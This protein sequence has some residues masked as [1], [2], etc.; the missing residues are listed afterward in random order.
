MINRD[1]ILYIHMDNT[2]ESIEQAKEVLASIYKDLFEFA[3]QLIDIS[4]TQK[5]DENGFY[6]DGIRFHIKQEHYE[7]LLDYP[8]REITEYLNKFGPITPNSLDWNNSI[9]HFDILDLKKSTAFYTQIK[10]VNKYLLDN[11]KEFLEKAYGT[12]KKIVFSGEQFTITD[13]L[14][15]K[16]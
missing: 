8:I 14:P 3:P 15:A 6:L 4:W 2:Q 16:H 9:N 12:N 11:G 10:T 13:L 1:G 7:E 5:V